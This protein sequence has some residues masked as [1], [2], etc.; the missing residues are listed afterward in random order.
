MNS[1]GR[2]WPVLRAFYR[3]FSPKLEREHEMPP[4]YVF[5]YSIM[6]GQ[7]DPSAG[8]TP[9]FLMAEFEN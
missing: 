6:M 7:A 5:S 2:R 3:G 1:R 4:E 8:D 9:V